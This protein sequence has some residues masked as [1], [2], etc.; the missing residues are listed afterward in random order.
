MS[1]RP[2]APKGARTANE[3]RPAWRL[4]QTVLLGALLGF[5]LPAAAR[6]YTPAGRCGD[7][8]R[9]DI[10]SPAGTCVALLADEAEG[11]RAPRRILEVA[12][13]RYWIADMGSWE[14]KRGRLLEMTLPADGPAPRRARIAVL[15][16]GLDRPS[17]L[18]L[19]PDGKVYVGEAGRVWRTPVGAPGAEPQR[20]TVLDGLPDDGTHPLKEIA[21]GPGDRLYVNV[22]SSSDNCRSGK[23]A[24]TLPCPDGEGAKPRAAV[25]EAQLAGPQ[26]TVQRFAP[27]ATGLRNSMALAVLP[28]TAGATEGRVLQGENSIDYRDAQS[29]PEELNLL[30]RGRFYGWP[31]CVGPRKNAQGY[32]G[33]FDCSKSEA[34]LALWPAH[35]APLQMLPG[36]AKTPFAG[37]LLVAW[38]GPQASG[39]RVVGFKLDPKTGLPAGP[40][41]DWLAGWHAKDGVRPMGRPTGLTV[42]RAGRLLVV[43][44]FNRTVLMLLPAQP[45]AAQPSSSAK[46]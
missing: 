38:R 7:F 4:L 26:R 21:F 36:P 24:P 25:Y 37:Q 28:A 20:E 19:A 10:P 45:P 33:R 32:E 29:P 9:L 11:L 44:D 31:Y 46:P 15:A 34:P 5:V 8:A 30:Q 3:A 35:A 42:D 1:A 18:A 23:D 27:F 14:P 16:S 12:P 22:G 40:A 39:H 43:E 13:G 6:G 41:I 17:G 2:S